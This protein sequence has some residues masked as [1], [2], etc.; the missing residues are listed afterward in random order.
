MTGQ[1]PSYLEDRVSQI[2]ALRLLMA[3]GWAYLP[4][5]EALAL[6]GGKYGNVILEDVLREWLGAHNVIRHKGETVAFSEANVSAA[7]RDLEA[8]PLQK[9]LIP[10]SEE[11]YELMTL[12]KSAE[13]TSR[14]RPAE[15]FD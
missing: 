6:R 4:P 7:V 3:M 9:G 2:P 13:Q 12:G 15:L 8:V 11:I 10:A 14:W 1:T 5:G